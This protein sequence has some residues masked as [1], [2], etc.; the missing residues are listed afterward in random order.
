M[1]AEGSLTFTQSICNIIT[2]HTHHPTSLI[3]NIGS[4]DHGDRNDLHRLAMVADQAIKVGLGQ[5][6][7]YMSGGGRRTAMIS[8]ILERLPALTDPL[9]LPFPTTLPTRYGES[10]LTSVVLDDP[11]SDGAA[12]E[13]LG[14]G[15]GC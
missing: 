2:S 3:P 1:I 13:A 9:P 10:T 12:E 14:G 8:Y 15:R 6:K 5:I 4:L 11:L 7:S